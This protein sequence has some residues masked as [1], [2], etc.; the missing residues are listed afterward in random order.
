MS[1]RFIVSEA[2]MRR[3]TCMSRSDLE[4]ETFFQL[5]KR[6][7]LKNETSNRLILRT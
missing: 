6:F 1:F 2:N 5:G 4:I 7:N 3:Y